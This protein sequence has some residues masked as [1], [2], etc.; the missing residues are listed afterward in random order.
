MSQV[1]L[2]LAQAVDAQ[3]FAA[4]AGAPDAVALRTLQR[5][6]LLEAAL[7]QPLRT[8]CSLQ[9]QVVQLLAVQRG[10]LDNVPVEQVGAGGIDQ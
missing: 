4:G 5:A 1:R 2:D 6:A 3:R 10:L 7:A 8:T 9:Q